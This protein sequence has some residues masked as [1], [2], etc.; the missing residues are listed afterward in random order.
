MYGL[1]KAASL[2]VALLANAAGA[3]SQPIHAEPNTDTRFATLEHAYVVYS[4][5]RYPVMATYLGGSGFDP[6]LAGVDGT[7]R[8]Y[9]PAAIAADDAHLRQLRSQF[10]QLEP[11]RLSAPR[12]IDRT[13]ALAQIEFLLHQHEVLRHQLNCLD[14]YTDEPVRGVDWQ[15]QGMTPTGT[16]TYGT[17]AQWE[18]VIARTRAVPAYL[19]TAR[20]Q[21]AAG[22][23]TGHPPDWR[24]L[25][26]FGL[27]GTAADGEYFAR[28]MPGIAQQALTGAN[29]EALLHQLQQVGKDAAAAYQQLRDYIASTFFL[30]PTGTDVRALKPQFRSD[31][32]ALGEAEYDWAL[33][34]NLHVATTAAALYAQSWPIVQ[35]ARARLTALARSVAQAHHWGL[36]GGSAPAGN[37]SAADATVRMVF[38]HLQQD[39][40]AND[41]AMI[42]DYRKT[43][44][45]LVNYA[46]T[47]HLF[48]VPAD[49]RLEVT[50]TPPPLRASIAS[51]AYYPAP[52]FTP[53]GVGRFYVTPTGDDPTLLGQLHNTAARADLAV[54]EG[55]PGHD[56]DYKVMAENR[57]VISALR[58]LTPGA[59]EDSSSMWE[60]SMSAEGWALYAEELM[61]EPQP[62]APHGV[63][64]PEEHLYEIRGELLRD[65]RVRLD[66]GIHTGRLSFEDAVTVLSEVVDFIPGSC[67][68]PAPLADAG[69]RASCDTARQEIARDARWPTQAVTYRLGKD[70]ILALRRR[71]QRLFGPEY[72]EQRFHLEFMQQGAIPASYFAEELL[73][74]LGRSVGR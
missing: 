60:D 34:N 15:I 4:M 21:L 74:D 51:A 23:R 62:G 3:A 39:A 61:A 49:Y 52:I 30:D 50:A 65:L 43:G 40:P 27:N 26:Q 31:R 35:A 48:A 32:Y 28:T 42:E 9:S 70:Q 19:A 68:A 46:R 71:A 17:E 13:V 1:R 58:W 10:A 44:E 64:S 8:D 54:H 72:S 14:S 67:R 66:T 59:V 38:E 45:R 2:L 41:A 53:D 57:A 56:W 11:R 25:M 24:V 6:S 12:R 37:G 29:R 33:H 7:L 73:R 47:T 36:P 55:F 5:S 16:L 69:K 18:Q 20:A 22:V 63:Y